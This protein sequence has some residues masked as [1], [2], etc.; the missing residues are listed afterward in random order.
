MAITTA[1]QSQLGQDT[2]KNS[3]IVTTAVK[4]VN[5]GA[6]TGP[7][8]NSVIITDSGYNNIDDTAVGTSNSFIK[9]IGSGFIDGA[10][11]FVGG[12]QVP[13]A[14]VTFT[15]SSELRVRL[16]VLTAGVN[17][18]I[19]IFNS[20]GSG[21]IFASNLLASGFPTV[22]TSSYTVESL[23]VNTQLLATG[24]GTLSYS[25]N[26]GSSLPLGLSLSSTGLISGT[27]IRDS[28]TSFTILVNDSQNQTTQQDITL[29]VASGDPYYKYTS[30]LIQADNTANNSNNGVVVDSSINNLIIT[31]NGVP[32]Q[33]TVNPFGVGTWSNYFT[34]N[35]LTIAA[36]SDMAVGTNDFTFETWIYP[37][38]MVTWNSIISTRP[39]AATAGFSNV[40]VL[41][42]HSTGYPYI[43][44]GDFQATGSANTIVNNIWT[45]VAVSRSGS[46]MRLFVN[47]ILANTAT[48]S[49][50]Y[51][52]NTA[53]IAGNNDGSEYFTGYISNARLLKGTALYTSNFTPTDTPL[54]AIANTVLLTCQSNRFKDEST[55]NLLITPTAN[56]S[57]QRFNPFGLDENSYEV[58]S[59]TFAGS[60]YFNGSSAA[61]N[62]S[63]SALNFGNGNFTV[64]M[65]FNIESFSATN[66]QVMLTTNPQ[67]NNGFQ[68]YRSYLTGNIVYGGINAGENTIITSGDY[69]TNTWYHIAIVRSGR[70]T[71]QTKTYLN[72]VQTGQYTDAT[73]YS[74]TGFSL[75]GYS[76]P[77]LY[78]NG[79]ISNVRA[80]I[81][82]LYSSNFT[83][84]TTP[85][86]VVD[87]T[88]LLLAQSSQSVIND[89]STNKFTM[90]TVGSPRSTRKT[91][92][93][94]T[95]TSTSNTTYGGSYYFNGS[96]EYYQTPMV[97]QLKLGANN[98]TIECWAYINAYGSQGVVFGGPWQTPGT[99]INGAWILGVLTTGATANLIFNSSTTGADTI[100]LTAPITIS[101]NTWNHFAVVRNENNLSSYFNG[102]LVTSNTNYTMT[103][104]PSSTQNTYIGY[105][106]AN[107]ISPGFLDMNGYISNFRIVNGTAVYI[108]EFTPPTTPLQPI[109]NT[110]L[111]LSGTNSGIYDSTLQTYIKTNNDA[112]V[113]RNV[114]KYGTGG[115]FFDG[116]NDNLLT[117]YTPALHLQ[118]S[119]FTIEFWI[120]QTATTGFGYVL[121]MGGGPNIALASWEF[122]IATSTIRFAASSSGVSYNIGGESSSGNIGSLSLNTWTHV[123]LTRSGSTFRGFINGV[124]GFSETNSGSL[125]DSN[126]R[127]LAIG[128][129]YTNT[130]DTTPPTNGGFIG[131]LDD[132]R[133]T[134]GYARYTANFTP[135]NAALKNK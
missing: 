40:W 101:K 5:S 44:S 30:L 34:G 73:N 132:I 95:D 92:F 33:G 109:A 79:Y 68:I 15:S 55:N 76:A 27:A 65:W 112:K 57:V 56:T 24:D 93:T 106:S 98:F 107:G 91:P 114:T 135:P 50:N 11:V 74:I 59:N 72:G 25:L 16:P 23:T 115:I 99:N 39:T 85:L 83:P 97:P 7:L 103:I 129:A 121:N 130:W 80:V 123:A 100:S 41:G 81:T 67:N 53:T 66:Y 42:F 70:G 90:V 52:D 116:T 12:T 36:S 45:H 19:S 38:A 105:N 131:Y 86:T 26:P 17:N 14:N 63:G 133:I 51:T 47:G 118:N 43:Y 82:A 18:T 127:G 77:G 8:I 78:F 108:S 84:S 110:A 75:G 13:A 1:S 64:E 134:K 89:E 87:S 58:S 88:T 102:N 9:I 94:L 122:Y 48:S 22:T 69:S 35:G 49:Q 104:N 124:Q 60:I 54:T 128:S 111:L 126:P 21:A 96:L 37:T 32:R 61:N 62:T 113:R 28:V 2:A 120:Y 6:S 46:T 29:T 20:A 3:Q 125:I 31:P 119:N 10:N 117:N 4:L 71:N